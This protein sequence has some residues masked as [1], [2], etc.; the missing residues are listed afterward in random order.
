MPSKRTCDISRVSF[1]FSHPDFNCRLWLLTSIHRRMAA[2]PCG[3]L[4]PSCG[5]NDIGASGAGVQS[6]KRVAGFIDHR[7]VSISMLPPVGNFTLPRRFACID[8]IIQIF[9][10]QP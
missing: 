6:A 1:P 9:A 7:R 3:S 8:I 5:C 10:R 2:M 4:I